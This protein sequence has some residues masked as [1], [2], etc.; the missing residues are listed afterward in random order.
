MRLCSVTDVYVS[1]TELY[2]VAAVRI[3]DVSSSDSLRKSL[4]TDFNFNG[5]VYEVFID[6]DVIISTDS[7]RFDLPALISVA[8]YMNF[9]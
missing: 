2:I 9:R 4:R 7:Y 6:G 3:V 5:F 8:Q 1:F